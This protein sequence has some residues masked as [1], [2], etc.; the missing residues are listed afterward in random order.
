M[1]QDV[2][3]TEGKSTLNIRPT[4]QPDPAHP[5]TLTFCIWTDDERFVGGSVYEWVQL[6]FAPDGPDQD[7]FPFHDDDGDEMRKGFSGAPDNPANR[8][9]GKWMR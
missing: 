4:P 2:W 8:P 6:D 9:K 7:G 1:G 5:D 3:N